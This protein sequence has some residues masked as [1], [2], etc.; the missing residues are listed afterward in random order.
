MTVEE[1]VI[2]QLS[3]SLSVPVG[4]AQ[5]GT[6]ASF[7]TVEQLGSSTADHTYTA[8]LAL[9]SWGQSRSEAAAINEEVKTKM[10]AVAGLPEVSRCR[11]EN[12][13]Y[14]PDLETKRPRYQAVFEVI[15]F[16]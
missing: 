2:E 13:Y 5:M 4:G 10:A 9:Q 11:L 15:L 16:T 14:F 3:A 6:D 1:F 12:D 7:V 8:S